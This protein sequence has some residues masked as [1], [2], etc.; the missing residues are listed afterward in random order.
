M[1]N[2]LDHCSDLPSRSFEKGDIVLK[3][4]GRDGEILFLK[5]GS[6][7]IRVGDSPITTITTKGA[8]LGEVA[9]LLNRG[10]TASAI[11]LKACDFYIL[12]NADK[13]LANHPE[14]SKEISRALARRLVRASESIAELTKQVEFDNDFGDFEMMM[15]WEEEENDI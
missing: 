3:E 1:S 8:M 2:S 14:I 6:V 5:S 11:A 9:V 7:E 4:G 10:H 12:E 15:L 13:E